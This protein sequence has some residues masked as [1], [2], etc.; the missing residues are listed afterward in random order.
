[1]G[2]DI[3]KQKCRTSRFCCRASG[4]SSHLPMQDE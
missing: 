3:I 4:F 2:E 1:L